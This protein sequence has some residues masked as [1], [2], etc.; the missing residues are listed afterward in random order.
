MKRALASMLAFAAA[1][2]LGCAAIG[3][4]LPFPD[5]QIA[6]ARIEHLAAQH[7]DYDTLLLGSSRIAYQ[8]IPSLFDAEMAAHAAP[9]RTFNAAVAGVSPPEDAYLLE[10]ILRHPPKDL[11]WVVLELAVMRTSVDRTRGTV[12]SVYWHDWER[13]R[14]VMHRLFASRWDAKKRSWKQLRVRLVEEWPVLIEHAQ[15]CAQRATNLG[16]GSL[17][18]DRLLRPD[19]RRDAGGV[20]AAGWQPTTRP[21]TMSGR[22]LEDYEQIGRASCRE[23]V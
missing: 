16:R 11:R 14:L 4:R 8:I 22:E 6:R 5:V 20:G 18:T 19:A 9:T 15:L 3:W 7:D 2:A 1:F 21:E 12:R 23:R 17:F 13:T 10:T